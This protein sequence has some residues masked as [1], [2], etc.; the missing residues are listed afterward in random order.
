MLQVNTV[1]KALGTVRL[2]C[3]S[4]NCSADT[5]AYSRT[6]ES[7]LVAALAVSESTLAVMCGAS[8]LGARAAL[9]AADALSRL[10]SQAQ[11]LLEVVL[12]AAQADTAAGG[13]T[14][15]LVAAMRREGRL[16]QWFSHLARL[17]GADAVAAAVAELLLLATTV[18]HSADVDAEVRLSDSSTG[19]LLYTAGQR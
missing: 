10:A 8:S 1:M 15:Q 7:W 2:V 11:P 14:S 19:M 13:T 6:A 17:R 16:L 3:G 18:E 9:L 5:T 4:P 12:D